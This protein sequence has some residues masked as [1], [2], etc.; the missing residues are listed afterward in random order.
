MTRG[1]YSDKRSFDATPEPAAPARGDVD[2]AT[3]RPGK[4]FVIHQHHARRLHFDLRLEMSSGDTTVLASWAVPKNL[5]TRPGV[6]HLAVHVEDHPLE[7]GS[8]TGTIPQG[9]YGAGEVRIF[10]SGTYELLEQAPGKLTFRLEG[11]RL[12]GVYHLT[13]TRAEE[14]KDEWLVF[15]KKDERHPPQELPPLEPML[16]TP[17]DQP[18]DDDDYLFEPKWD[19]VRTIAVCLSDTLL[20]SRRRRDVTGTYPE[21]ARLHERLVATGAVLDGEIVAFEGG[22]PSFERLQSRINLQ[23]A[24]D[25]QRAMKS[26]PVSYIAFDLLYLDGRRVI[27]RPLEERK[28][29]LQ[30]L[31]VGSEIVRVSSPSVEGEGIALARAAEQMR[32]EGVVAKKLGC[33]YRPGR[34]SRDWLKIKVIHEAD[35]VVAG[36]SPGEGNRSDAFGALLVGAYDDRGLRFVGAV[37][38][39]FTQA[40]L[41]AIM[42]ELHSR[43]T[44]ECPFHEDCSPLRVGRAGGKALR[45]PHWTRPELVATIEFRELTSSGRLRAPS[46]KSVRFDKEPSECRFDDLLPVTSARAGAR[47]APLARE[48][49]PRSTHCSRRASTTP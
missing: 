37:G 31:V 22:R 27:D 33:P 39:G 25:I 2:L 49:S 23:N 48:R 13:R 41:A 8:F 17:H 38:T 4:S 34:R 36:W 40:S 32:L 43:R 3:A 47:A 9:N 14:G 24:H 10:D 7:Y 1:T 18:F 44:D 12:R 29:L 20:L 45:Y 46:F 42:P 26:I 15:M 21:L 35:V 11:T 5:P 19:G 30:E 16:A 6:A 28:E